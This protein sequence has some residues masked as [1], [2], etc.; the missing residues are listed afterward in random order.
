VAGLR[1]DD[2]AMAGV[3]LGPIPRFDDVLESVDKRAAS[4]ILNEHEETSGDRT[5]RRSPGRRVRAPEQTLHVVGQK[6][7]QTPAAAPAESNDIPPLV[8][9]RYEPSISG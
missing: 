1:R 3:I 5:K 6:L 4:A 7:N 2:D 9:C 8:P